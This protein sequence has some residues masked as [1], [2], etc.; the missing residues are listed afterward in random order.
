M[1]KKLLIVLIIVLLTAACSPAASPANNST[2]EATAE[3]ATPTPEELSEQGGGETTTDT[4]PVVVPPSSGASEDTADDAS[5]EE[6]APARGSREELEAYTGWTCPEAVRGGT[7][8]VYN[9][10]TYV[11]PDTISNFEVLCEATVVYDIYDGNES[12]LA[13]LR[14]GNPGYDIAVPTD[15]A[16]AIMITEGLVEPLDMAN[17]PNFANVSANLKN[18][19]SDPESAYSVPYQWGTIGI[20]YNTT[21]VTEVP[22]SWDDMFN[23]EGNVAWLEDT[24]GVIG[25]A[26]IMLGLDPNTTDPAEIE[27]ARDYLAAR[28]T[29]VR[30]IAGDDGQALLER[31]EVDMTIEYNGDIFQL[32]DSCECDTYAYVVPNEGSQIWV[33]NLVIPVDA[34]N[35]P[36]AEAFIDYILSPQVGADLSNFTAYASPN[37][38][39]I[40]QQLIDAEY[41]NNPAIYPPAETLSNLFF[42]REVPNDVASLYNDAWD[43]IKILIGG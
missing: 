18:P 25:I 27:Q 26:L 3:D 15:Y 6:S 9:W 12:L 40:D 36:L 32:I 37:Q 10:S 43:Q 38:A 41:L 13:R 14:S 16:V 39:S 8:N 33:D 20:G 24:R 5:E 42:I 11:A 2:E 31:G 22:D 17:I 21:T 28:G 30:Y 23:F 34:P 4:A 7:L 35:K 19:P 29:N 1:F